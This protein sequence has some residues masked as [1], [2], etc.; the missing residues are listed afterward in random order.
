MT[1][2][3]ERDEAIRRESE[4]LIEQLTSQIASGVPNPSVRTYNY[5]ADAVEGEIATHFRERRVES[6]SVQCGGATLI[7]IQ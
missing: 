5:I 4:R 2:I 1:C 6:R 7:T 3:Q